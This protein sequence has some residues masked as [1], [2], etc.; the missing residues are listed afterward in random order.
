MDLKNLYWSKES[1][2]KNLADKKPRFPFVLLC[3]LLPDQ[4]KN[5]LYGN[6][7]LFYEEILHQKGRKYAWFR[8]LGQ[9]LKSSPGLIMSNLHWR[10]SMLKNYLKV[11]LRNITR[12]K[13]FSGINIIG[14][15]IG[16]ACFILIL[17][18][19]R[20]EFSFDRFQKNADNIYRVL[21][22]SHEKETVSYSRVIPSAVGPALENEIPE[23]KNFVRIFKYYINVRYNENVFS[24]PDASFV[25]KNFFTYFSF[26]MIMGDP[27]KVLT[28]PGS[29]VISERKAGQIFGEKNPIGETLEIN[30]NFDYVVTG[31][32]RIPENT[33]L[34]SDYFLPVQAAN[35][36]ERTL[37]DLESN[38]FRWEYQTFV[39]LN[40]LSNPKAVEKKIYGILKKRR[41]RE[42]Y[43]KLQQLC[44]IHLYNMD[45]SRGHITDLYV[46]SIVAVFLL[47][48]ACV[49]YMNLSTARYI[50][51]SREIGLRKTVGAHRS[52]IIMQ[53]YSES[54]LITILSFLLSIFLVV[55]ALP[56]FNTVSGKDLSFDFL[57]FDVLLPLSG[58]LFL[59]GIVAG[60]Y[61]A[62]FLSSFEPLRVIR[63]AI[64]SSKKGISLRKYLV[65]V[66]FLISIILILFTFTVYLQ[67]KFI[68]NKD[69]GY[70]RE[71][72][73]YIQLQDNSDLKLETVKKALVKHPDIL[74][75]T[76]SF[77]L[78][79]REG[80]GY[81][82]FLDWEGRE[83]DKKVYFAF[84]LVD[85][86][87]ISTFDMKIVEGRGFSKEHATDINGFI[88]N[89]EA[90]KQMGIKS[91]VG[92]QIN[93]WG[94]EGKIIGTVK[95]FHLRHMSSL[96]EPVILSPYFFDFNPR[97]LTIKVTP[98]NHSTAIEHFRK[99]WKEIN[100]GNAFE[101]RFFEDKLEDMY[102]NEQRFQSILFAFALLAIFISCLGLF[103]LTAFMVE[104]RKK[105]IGIRK[106]LGASVP[107]I[108]LLLA[109]E[110]TIWVITANL[111]AWPIG[112]YF[113]NKWLLT[114]A[115]KINLG[116]NIFLISGFIALTV[117][118]MT[119]SFQTIRASNKNPVDALRHE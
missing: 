28:D 41:Q 112:F 107:N 97:Y 67:M 111:L 51:R 83:N 98:G 106:T 79:S 99:V 49:N 77:F 13:G 43:L 47:F 104:Q 118:I 119:T 80:G 56:Y 53:F 69:V 95:N 27:N 91:P 73:V 108:I 31:V 52:Q 89:E 65:L 6:F 33:V 38:W 11:A 68:G 76:A 32:V 39:T 84:I 55:L 34:K 15:S 101:Y 10:L 48:I 23:I 71:N 5:P 75:A 92:K 103:G 50:K 110:Y 70:G 94:R 72:L 96:I 117:A 63:A 114:F 113:I 20:N 2:M 74:N 16:I 62:L 25:D 9:I 88:L 93:L 29:I 17:L 115:Y 44:D 85:Y 42:V 35:L 59:T 7:E 87:Y 24:E 105:E 26:K 30:E 3:I 54:I 14:L 18:Y 60:S 21:T 57:N 90:V 58:I 46:F 64:A 78:P 86:Y 8:I 102:K 100:P 40:K 45:G 12:S 109:K 61:P 4:K 82:G 116:I 81:A 1:L 37:P 19:V 22:E 66:Q 36:F